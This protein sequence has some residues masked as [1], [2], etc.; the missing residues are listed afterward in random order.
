MLSHSAIVKLKAILV[1]DLIIIGL[2]AG[3]YL[4]LQHQGL[5][6]AAAKPAKFTLLNLTIDPP[7]TNVTDAV[8]ISAN[9]TNVGALEGNDT[10]NLEIN[11]ATAG[12]ENVTLSGGAS[13][14]VQFTE[15]ELIP[16]NY[17]VQVG[18]LTGMFVVNPAPPGSSKI[19]LSNLNFNP[20]EA[21]P[22]QPV[23]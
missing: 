13:Q 22:N 19:I 17:T 21:W 7:V 8:E 10:I 1:I 23:K 9:V 14:L 5:I 3:A 12:T 11:N 18:D 16:G 15:I 4:Y 20:Y 6:V 2:A